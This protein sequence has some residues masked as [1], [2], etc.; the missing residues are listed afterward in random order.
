MWLQLQRRLNRQ[1]DSSRSGRRDDALAYVAV[2]RMVFDAATSTST[3]LAF[4]FGETM[5]STS[6][7]TPPSPLY[8]FVVLSLATFLALFTLVRDR[9][10]LYETTS[11][12]STN[13]QSDANHAIVEMET[14][15]RQVESQ[16][17]DAGA[18]FAAL[19]HAGLI[20]ENVDFDSDNV[21]MHRVGQNIVERMQLQTFQQN[22]T[23][24]LQLSLLTELPESGTRMLDSMLHNWQ[25]SPD[26]ADSL[27]GRTFKTHPAIVSRQHG[28]SV[29]ALKLVLLAIAASMVGVLGLVMLEHTATSS[30]LFTGKE[31]KEAAGI[32][33]IVD[34]ATSHDFPVRDRILTQRKAFRVCVRVAE[35][36]VAA[37]F[38]LML[39]QLVTRDALATRFVADPLAAYGEVLTR[40]IG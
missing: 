18:V 35:V 36:V 37:V 1:N 21:E 7:R 17:L 30:I 25:S 23:T 34:F 39:Q 12:F 28:G 19:Q 5:A 38:L 26:V 33:V 40:V 2:R 10:V 15:R 20:D 4:R 3:Q 29:S 6:V 13:L 27:A 22:D 14:L 8:V 24:F 11:T 31:V 9:R 32:P 16:L